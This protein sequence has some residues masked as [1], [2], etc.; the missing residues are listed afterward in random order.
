MID[1][2]N[3]QD[4]LRTDL[5]T[6]I[7]DSIRS[8]IVSLPP[9][10]TVPGVSNFRDLSHDTKLRP[11]F[12]YRAGNLSD[13]SDEGKEVISK[14]LGVT[15]IFDLRNS[16]ERERAPSPDIP[17]TVTIWE[18]YGHRPAS[19]N[20]RDFAKEDYGITG[21]EK[22]YTG[23]LD[24]SQPILTHIFTHI[25][26]EPNDPFIYHCSAGKDRTGVVSALILLLVGH[27]HEEIVDD[28]MFTR[29]ALEEARENLTAALAMGSGTDHLS[30]EAMGMIQ[31]SG[32]SAKA[33]A[34]FL[35]TFQAKYGGIEFFLITT[36]GFTPDDVE[37][38][39]KN[40]VES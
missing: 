37:Q 33:M 25:R 32:V 36:L 23:I 15:T 5:T 9:F 28:Y 29:V 14:D 40:L 11:G 38:M 21:F 27:S 16:S 17:G 6:A 4:V 34:T 7:P 18:P 3:V 22:M 2:E 31:L 8:K 19:I 39:R 20:L 13:I 26:D 1:A 35:D 10:I 24:A 30:P 12:V